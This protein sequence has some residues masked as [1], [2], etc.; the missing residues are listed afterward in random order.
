MRK[1]SAH[2]I[3]D[4]KGTFLKNAI[5]IIDDEGTI[6][7]LIHTK[8]QLEESEGIEFYN[9]IITPGFINAHCHLELS[10][11]KGVIAAK[12]GLVEFIKNVVTHRS[13]S[14]ERIHLAIADAIEEMK[15]NGIVA[16]GD[17]SNKEITFAIKQKS[18]LYFY[19]FLECFGVEE[20]ADKMSLEIANGLYEKWKNNIPISLV[21]HASYSCSPLLLGKIQINQE[22]RSG[23][24]SIHNQEC[25]SEN[26]LFLKKNGTLFDGLIKMGMNLDSLEYD[27]LNSVQTVSKYFPQNKNKILVHNT[28]TN[29]SDIQFLFEG[30]DEETLFWCLCP[31]SNL[32]IENCL[33][34]INLFYALKLQCVLGTDGYSSNTSLS[35]LEELKTISSNFASIPLSETL[36]W[37]CY[38]GAK[39]LSITDRYGSFEK[40]KRPGINL[41]YDIDLST[42]KILPN[43]QVKVLV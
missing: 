6:I 7:D 35:I 42:L 4:G 2:Y 24:Y 33:P 25:K 13:S 39:A 34:D 40:G 31:N 11:M 29:E 12:Q 19:T 37:A 28:F 27:G 21:A 32:Y 8:G 22:K 14:E 20:P 30:F 1:I 3:F 15:Q 18:D 36:K 9:G 26:E 23:I 10:H 17:I 43:S 16:V 41:I 38:N 5:I